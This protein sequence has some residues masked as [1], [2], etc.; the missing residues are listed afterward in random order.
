MNC[1]SGINDRLGLTAISAID[2][3]GTPRAGPRP[4]TF[5]SHDA[6]TLAG[7]L[8]ITPAFLES[9]R[10]SQAGGGFLLQAWRRPCPSRHAWRRRS[11]VENVLIF[12]LADSG[13]T[14][15]DGFAKL[16]IGHEQAARRLAADK[17]TVK[18]HAIEIACRLQ[19]ARVNVDDQARRE[20]ARLNEGRN[21][22]AA[23]S[24][25]NSAGS[26]CVPSASV[27][28]T[29]HPSSA[30]TRAFATA[31]SKLVLSLLTVSFSLSA[32]IL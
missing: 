24:R 17:L 5:S 12:S 26:N 1:A 27:T 10:R 18:R 11:V 22:Y 9:R 14:L 31:T 32:T 30:Q 29:C 4:L 20:C 21:G 25:S 7:G 16:G 6:A 2:V 13:E 23:K 8:R 19:C 15:R 3:V 28:T